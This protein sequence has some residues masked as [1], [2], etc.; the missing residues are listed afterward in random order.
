MK[1]GS[2]AAIMG[3]SKPL[4]PNELNTKDIIQQINIRITLNPNPWLLEDLKFDLDPKVLPIN[5][6]TKHAK[7]K[8][9]FS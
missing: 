9:N 6:N 4:T 3:G 1:T 8:V 2:H 7:G 5:P